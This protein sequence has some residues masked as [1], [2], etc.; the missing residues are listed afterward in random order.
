[1]ATVIRDFGMAAEEVCQDE[2]VQLFK[3]KKVLILVKW[4]N[5]SLEQQSKI[6]RL[7]MFLKEKFEDEVF[8]KLK[9]RIVADG[10]TQDS[11]INTAANYKVEASMDV[12]IICSYERMGVIEGQHR[13][14][15]PVGEDRRKRRSIHD[16]GQR[17]VNY[18]SKMDA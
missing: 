10:C 13:R 3:E 8:M 6:V 16:T 9:T 2:L 17:H 12:S 4:D 1:M 11:S 14:D 15:V 18:G 5:L 7:H